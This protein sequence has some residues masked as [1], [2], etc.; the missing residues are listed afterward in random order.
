MQHSLVTKKK[1]WFHSPVVAIV[2]IIAIAFGVVSVIKIY[3]K[4]KEAVRLRNDYQRQVD[5]ANAKQT[6][7]GTK[8]S[9]LSTPRG[10]EEEVREKYRVVKPGEQLV[11]V[12]D[13]GTPVPPPPPIP[14]WRKIFDFV[15]F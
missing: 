8:I 4:E 15:G 13:N 9:N 10:Q 1:T 6:D 14:W 11:I 5:E 12:V 3:S 7:L 2:L